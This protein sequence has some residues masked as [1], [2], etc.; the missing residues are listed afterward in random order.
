[1]GDDGAFGGE[2]LE[3]LL[4]ALQLDSMSVV[5]ACA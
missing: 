4:A 2:M 1:L 3:S 5:D